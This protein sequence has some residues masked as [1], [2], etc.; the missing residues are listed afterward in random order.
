[1]LYT[2]D[3]FPGRIYKLSLDGKLLG[4][5]GKAGKEMRAF[6]WIHALACPSENTLIAAEII[7]WR[8]QKLILHPGKDEK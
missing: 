3:A 7:N 6:G 5:L 1:V 4:M 8:V 2:A